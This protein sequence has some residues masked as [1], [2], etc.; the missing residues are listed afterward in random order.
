MGKTE[1]LVYG[2]WS[3][4]EFGMIAPEFAPEN[5]WTGEN[6]V[7]YKNGR[8]GPRPGTRL[9]NQGFPT[10]LG[11]MKGFGFTPVGGPTATPIFFVIGKKVWL[12]DPAGVGDF[13]E[14]SGELAIE[15]GDVPRQWILSKESARLLADEVFFPVDSDKTYRLDGKTQVLTGITDSPEG[16]DIET[17]RD[18]LFV[19]N[20]ALRVN[21]SGPAD[22]NSWPSANFFDVGPSW[23][24]TNMA[25][26]RDSMVIFTQSGTWV[27]TGNP[28]DGTLRRLSDTLA[29]STKSIVR[30]NDDILYIPE[31][32]SAPVQFNGSYGDERILSYLENWKGQN[33][34]AFGAQSYGNRDVLFLSDTSRL[35]WRKNGAWSYHAMGGGVGPWIVRYFDDHVLLGTTGSDSDDPDFYMLAMNLNRPAFTSD[36]WARPGDNTDTPLTAGFTLPDYFDPAGKQVRPRQVTVD[37]VR[38]N[39]GAA[40]NNHLDVSVVALARNGLD[41]NGS[42]EIGA[43]VFDQA[44]SASSTGGTRDRLV[45]PIGLSGEHGGFRISL[46]N[47][48]GVAIS[49]VYVDIE[50]YEGRPLA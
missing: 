1:T 4:G 46:N 39:T 3:G 16:N 7:V 49:K 21:F 37:F 34:Y 5:S 31:S 25:E 20:G 6:V 11:P 47:L 41:G 13:T 15:P 2:N 29:P 14:A 26:F 8:I 18:R 9:V 43:K 38:Y 33:T 12:F 17:Y 35:L 22:F 10:P 45:V 24:I 30:T 28:D 36:Q 27:L 50:S 32:R 40:V 19:S 42:S 48:K 23:L 44:G